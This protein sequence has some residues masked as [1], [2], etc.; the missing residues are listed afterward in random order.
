MSATVHSASSTWMSGTP[1]TCTENSVIRVVCGPT[2]RPGA[3]APNST[4]TGPAS[5][6]TSSLPA[7]MSEAYSPAPKRSP[8]PAGRRPSSPWMRVAVERPHGH[9]GLHHRDR[10]RVVEQRA[11]AEA[12]GLQALER[13]RLDRRAVDVGVEADV[14]EEHAVGPRHGALAQHHGLRAAE[15]VRQLPQPLAQVG[16]AAAGAGGERERVQ[17]QLGELRGHLRVDPAG[18]DLAHRSASS[19]AAS[20]CS[21]SSENDVPATLPLRPA[22]VIVGQIATA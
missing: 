2:P 15:A 10:Q 5:S 21:P 22:N 11:R 9:A 12:A 1:A 18:G 4:P 14:A 6:A 3:S 20:A 19:R 16:R 8:R 13:E 17:A 7:G